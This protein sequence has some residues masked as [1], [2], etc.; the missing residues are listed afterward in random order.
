MKHSISHP[1]GPSVT[2]PNG[3]EVKL[4]HKQRVA[5]IA[6]PRAQ[7]RAIANTTEQADDVIDVFAKFLL[8]EVYAEAFAP[9][10][11]VASRSHLLTGS[12]LLSP[13][14]KKSHTSL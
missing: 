3:K 13:Q 4:V 7:V 14:A 8:A 9:S 6:P 1:A 12:F 10:G 5:S 2:W 11:G